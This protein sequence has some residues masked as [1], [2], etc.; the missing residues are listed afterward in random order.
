M[1]KVKVSI[2]VTIYNAADYIRECLDFL[3]NQ[4]L[5]EIEVFNR[6]FNNNLY[7]RSI[8]ISNE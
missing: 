7:F 8:F 4:T 5:K 6:C 2:I 3:A 1:N